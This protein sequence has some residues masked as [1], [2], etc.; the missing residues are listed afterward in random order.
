MTMQSDATKLKLLLLSDLEGQ[1]PRVNQLCE[2]LVSSDD[3]NVDAV[4]VIGGLVA[5]R[6]LQDYE[7]LE[8]VAAAE[9]DMMALISRLEMIICR[10]LYIPDENDP[11]TTRSIV[12]STPSLTQYSSNVYCREEQ[13]VEGVTVMGE[14][15]YFKL[16]KDGKNPMQDRDM[17]LVLRGSAFRT[18]LPD[19]ESSFFAGLLPMLQPNKPKEH[20]ALEV[21]GGDGDGDQHPHAQLPLIYPGS[22]RLGQY[23]ILQLEKDP[24]E[25]NWGVTAVISHQLE[26]KD[27]EDDEPTY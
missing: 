14:A 22:L 2:E 25:D 27:D 1:I 5:K 19:V 15:R 13:L 10:V 16:V 12:L 6:G 3:C 21:I 24:L 18:R 11:P 26:K 8:A 23:T 20:R 7:A 4:L 9:G 17:V